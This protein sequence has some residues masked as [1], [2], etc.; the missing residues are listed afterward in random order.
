MI[1]KIIITFFVLVF[2]LY[3]LRFFKKN[4]SKQRQKNENIIDLE[5]DPKTDE[6][7]PKE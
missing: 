3:G 6:Y 1:S 5:K 4:K 7:K 2:C